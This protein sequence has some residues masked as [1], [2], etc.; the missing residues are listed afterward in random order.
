M[1]LKQQIKD[2]IFALV[3]LVAEG[4][5]SWARSLATK[6][7]RL[8]PVG[9]ESLP[10]ETGETV[11][12]V[13]DFHES[14]SLERLEVAQELDASWVVQRVYVGRSYLLH[15]PIHSSSLCPGT[16][17]SGK[18]DLPVVSPGSRVH[19]SAKNVGPASAVFRVVFWGAPLSPLGGR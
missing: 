12:I 5:T 1:T 15:G 4:A 19:V 13:V 9:A 2:F 8:V 3:S 7:G 11:E 17:G 14:M 10:I 6:K 18:I 16:L